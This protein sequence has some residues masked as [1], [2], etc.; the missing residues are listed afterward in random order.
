MV[1]LYLRREKWGAVCLTDSYKS[2]RE[3]EIIKAKRLYKNERQFSNNVC[4]ELQY[5]LTQLEL[6]LSKL[7]LKHKMLLMTWKFAWIP[8]YILL[9]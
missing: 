1:N 7:S 4:V 9:F 3:T 6:Q 2:F 5:L 8:E